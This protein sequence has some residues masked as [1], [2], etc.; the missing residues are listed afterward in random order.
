MQIDNKVIIVAVVVGWILWNLFKGWK[1][2]RALFTLKKIVNNY[3]WPI[4]IVLALY[5]L[6]VSSSLIAPINDWSLAQA[7]VWNDYSII[8]CIFKSVPLASVLLI[9]YIVIKIGTKQWISYN[10][11]EKIWLKEEDDNSWI[12]KF[13][14]KYKILRMI[15]GKNDDN[16]KPENKNPY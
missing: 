9:I 15:C 5:I 11:N 7:A 1:K 4:N 12:T 14:K 2:G 10:D 13:I 8:C 3:S 16:D 6:I